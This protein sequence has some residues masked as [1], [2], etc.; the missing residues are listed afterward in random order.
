MCLGG[1]KS[2]PRRVVMYQRRGPT[3]NPKVSAIRSSRG[4]WHYIP[5]HRKGSCNPN[6][7]RFVP[8]QGKL[9][10]ASPSDTA[11]SSSVHAFPLL[12]FCQPSPSILQG[13]L[14]EQSPGKMLGFKWQQCW[15]LLNKYN[16][17]NRRLDDCEHPI[18]CISNAF[19][20]QAL[21]CFH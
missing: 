3:L 5:L 18:P 14:G 12:W 2:R 8:S 15:K 9:V 1:P 17:R 11:I 4:H 21:I 20:F 19:T 7:C 10:L 6:K 13:T 16:L